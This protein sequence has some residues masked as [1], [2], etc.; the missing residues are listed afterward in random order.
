MFKERSAETTN[1][2][3]FH[4]SLIARRRGLIASDQQERPLQTNEPQVISVQKYR[5]WEF[6]NIK[7]LKKGVAVIR[8][9]KKKNNNQKI[10]IPSAQNVKIGN[11]A[12]NS[13]NFIAI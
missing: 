12:I 13:P 4:Q 1:A 9:K 10:N 3:P 11:D 5:D 6:I 8:D 7:S 2:S